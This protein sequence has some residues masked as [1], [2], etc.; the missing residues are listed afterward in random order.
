M[1][2]FC[3]GIILLEFSAVLSAQHHKG[4]AFLIIDKRFIAIAFIE[5]QN[6]YVIEIASNAVFSFTTLHG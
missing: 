6:G 3:L 5:L 4:K 2:L 1:R